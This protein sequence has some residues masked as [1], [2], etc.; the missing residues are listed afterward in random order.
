MRTVGD[1]LRSSIQLADSE[2]QAQ[3]LS[4]VQQQLKAVH[5]IQLKAL[6]S[7]QAATKLKYARIIT[8]ARTRSL[9]ALD[10]SGLLVKLINCSDP[11]KAV[12]T[13]KVSQIQPL[14]GVNSLCN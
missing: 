2:R 3:A 13:V 1:V 9:R 6:L 10:R 8:E 14:C 11:D 12:E 7:T 5:T 4:D